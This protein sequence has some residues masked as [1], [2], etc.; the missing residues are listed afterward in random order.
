MRKRLFMNILSIETSCDE[1]AVAVTQD[2]KKV[3]SSVLYSQ[4]K[5]HEIFGGVV[6]EVASRK[7]IELISQITDQALRNS[8]L[9]F[10]EIDCVA[11]TNSPGLIGALL[12]GVNF[13]KGLAYSLEK[14][15]VPVNHIHGHIASNYIDNPDLK[16]PFLCLV[17]S[18]G[19][20]QIVQVLNHT[21]FKVVAT[22]RDDAVGEVFDKI[23]RVLGLGY[24]GG[25]KIEKCAFDGDD[26]AYKLPFPKIEGF[27]FSFSGLKTAVINLVYKLK[28]K[29]HLT[30]IDIN[31]IAAS[32]QKTAVDILVEKFFAAADEFAQKSGY[33]NLALAGGVSANRLLRE[34][35]KTVAC[36]KGYSL[37]LPDLKW[38]GDNAA[39][40]GFQA[41]HEYLNNN[42]ASLDLNASAI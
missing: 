21:D 17:V 10:Q 1:T 6:P 14:P 19:H 9:S 13:A 18:G 16:P 42:V 30:Q 26:M 4:I 38:C 15:L 8:N 2:G 35:L 36:K 20:T 11:V 33:Q 41:Y 37:F 32:F 28:Q 25:V 3:L 24:P 27:D 23:A 7:H 39:M 12:V 29:S 31:N 5:E 40:I 34:R 22:T